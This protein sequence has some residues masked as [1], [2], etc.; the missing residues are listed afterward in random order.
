MNDFL[1]KNGALKLFSVLIAIL[2]WI[3]VVQIENPQFEVS[4]Q[5]VPI[6]LVN[7]L[8]LESKGLVIVE[9]SSQS[10]NLRLKGK[11][12]SVIGLKAEDISAVIDVGLIQQT[13][14]FS[15]APQLS[16][17]DD[18]ISVLE[19]NPR[20][21]TFVIDKLEERTFGITP[22]IIGHPKEGYYAFHSE[23]EQK[24]VVIKGPTSLLNQ[25][26][27][28]T[29]GLDVEGAKK[30]VKKKVKLTIWKDDGTKMESDKIEIFTSVVT[31]Q[32][33]IF[34]TKKLKLEYNVT[35]KLD[36]EG[37]SL[38]ET[39]ISNSTVM[40]AGKQ[41]LLEKMETINLGDFD[42]SKVTPEQ[43]KQVFQIPFGAEL[44][45]ADGIKNVAVEA[46]L[47]SDKKKTSETEK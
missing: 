8:Q 24:E 47:I 5:N 27:K 26:T 10:T 38:K 15:F 1:K 9:Q 43:Y 40:V 29:A 21:I 35:G 37:Y 45:S 13:G 44:L 32:C 28:V 6:R 23:T 42:L 7:E 16:F 12:Q 2:M 33:N 36:V 30:D 39:V 19:R 3:Y 41:E 11:R 34:P 4:V 31:V 46:V 17:P 22:E 20:T 14:N 18:G 25:I